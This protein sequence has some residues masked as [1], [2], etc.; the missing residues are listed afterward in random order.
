MGGNGPILVMSPRTSSNHRF[1]PVLCQGPRVRGPEPGFPL[2]PPRV[3]ES[4]PF[5]PRH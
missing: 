1:D 3:P 2:L 4:T 5:V